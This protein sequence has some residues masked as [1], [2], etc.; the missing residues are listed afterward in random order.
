[1]AFVNLT[2]GNRLDMERPADTFQRDR[3]VCVRHRLQPMY[4]RVRAGAAYGHAYD[5]SAGGVRVELD[6]PPTVGSR[7]DVHLA[8]PGLADGVNVH[9]EVVWVADVNDD[10]GPRRLALRFVSFASKLDEKRLNDALD[11]MSYAVAI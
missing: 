8:W 4:T 5:V 3:R 10:P 1:M 2:R 6:D 11:R 7:T 9:G